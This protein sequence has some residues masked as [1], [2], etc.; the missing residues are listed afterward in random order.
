MGEP[1]LQKVMKK[2]KR[3]SN[4]MFD[5]EQSRDYVNSQRQSLPKQ[6]LKLDKVD[7][8]YVVNMSELIEKDRDR[9]AAR[10]SWI[11]GA[12]GN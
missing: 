10:F 4:A 5:L 6:L 11:P 12:S 9:L 8:P 1:L 7:V 2:G 3:V